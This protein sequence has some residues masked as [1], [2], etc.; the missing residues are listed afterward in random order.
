MPAVMQLGDAVTRML[1]KTASA[2]SDDDCSY[3]LQLRGGPGST[4]HKYGVDL[5]ASH[6]MMQERKSYAKGS[7]NDVRGLPPPVLKLSQTRVGRSTRAQML[8]KPRW[9]TSVLAEE[10]EKPSRRRRTVDTRNRGAGDDRDSE[11]SV[12]V[13]EDVED[14]DG[15]GRREALSVE[16]GTSVATLLV[17]RRNG[18][19][20]ID[21]MGEEDDSS[22]R[23]GNR[24][25][26]KDVFA[27]H[28]REELR[29][30]E[31][32]GVSRRGSVIAVDRTQLTQSGAAPHSWT[33]SSAGSRQT[34]PVKQLHQQG[35]AT[36]ASSSTSTEGRT[37]RPAPRPGDS[38]DTL[39][40]DKNAANDTTTAFPE[41]DFY[42][43][44]TFDLVQHCGAKGLRDR[45]QREL[46]L[47]KDMRNPVRIDLQE[48]RQLHTNVLSRKEEAVRKSYR[49]PW[50]VDKNYFE[51]KIEAIGEGRE[52]EDDER[53]SATASTDAYRYRQG[54]DYST[55]RD[56]EKKNN[57]KVGPPSRR[58]TV[59][60]HQAQ[61]NSS[62]ASSLSTSTTSGVDNVDIKSSENSGRMSV[63]EK[64]LMLNRQSEQ[65]VLVEASPENAVTLRKR[66]R[67]KMVANE[68]A[69]ESVALREMRAK[70]M[71][72]DLKLAYNPL[73]G[74]VPEK[75]DKKHADEDDA[76]DHSASPPRSQKRRAVTVSSQKMIGEPAT[77][78]AAAGGRAGDRDT[79]LLSEGRSKKVAGPSSAPGPPL[80]PLPRSIVEEEQS[81]EAEVD[82]FSIGATCSDSFV[83][84][85]TQIRG[86]NAAIVRSLQSQGLDTD[87]HPLAGLNVQGYGRRSQCS[88]D[89]EY[90][91]R[92]PD[93]GT[94]GAAGTN[95]DSPSAAS[96][97]YKFTTPNFTN[98]GKQ[99]PLG[100]PLH[101]QPPTGISFTSTTTRFPK[102]T[103]LFSRTT[104]TAGIRSEEEN[105][106][107]S[108]LR[109]QTDVLGIVIDASSNYTAPTG[110][111]V[112][113]AQTL[114]HD[115]EEDGTA[116]ASSSS[117][118]GE[119]GVEQTPSGQTQKS[120]VER[121]A[122]K[123]A[124]G[125]SSQPSGPIKEDR[126]P[127]EDAAVSDAQQSGTAAIQ[128]QEEELVFNPNYMDQFAGHR[129]S[130]PPGHLPQNQLDAVK[131]EEGHRH[132]P[133][134]P[135]KIKQQ[136][137][138]MFYTGSMDHAAAVGHDDSGKYASQEEEMELVV[139]GR[140]LDEGS[141][142]VASGWAS[143][144]RQNLLDEQQGSVDPSYE[145]SD[146]TRQR[147]LS[148]TGGVDGHLHMKNNQTSKREIPTKKKT[149]SGKK[150][151]KD[152]A[153]DDS[154]LDRLA[155]TRRQEKSSILLRNT[156][157]ERQAVLF[158][159]DQVAGAASSS[160]ASSGIDNSGGGGG[161][162]LFAMQ[163]AINYQRHLVQMR[164]QDEN[165][166]AERLLPSTSITGAALETGRSAPPGPPPSQAAL[167]TPMHRNQ[168]TNDS[169]PAQAV[170]N[171]GVPGLNS[172]RQQAPS[173]FAGSPAAT[174][175]SELI[176]VRSKNDTAAPGLHQVEHQESGSTRERFW[177]DRDR[178]AAD[179]RERNSN[180]RHQGNV[181]NKPG[182]DL[183]VEPEPERAATPPAAKRPA[184]P[185]GVGMPLASTRP[186]RSDDIG[187]SDTATNRPRGDSLS[188]L[189]HVSGD[190]IINNT[191]RSLSQNK[192]SFLPEP[193]M[194]Q[195]P[196][197]SGGESSAVTGAS[198]YSSASRRAS[199][200]ENV[201]PPGGLKSRFRHTGIDIVRGA[202]SSS[203][204]G[205]FPA[206]QNYNSTVKGKGMTTSTTSTS[207]CTNPGAN[208]PSRVNKPTATRTSSTSSSSSTTT[209][210][211][212]ST[213][214]SASGKRLSLR[215]ERHKRLDKPFFTIE[216]V[217]ITA[218]FLKTRW[219]DHLV[220]KMKS[221]L[222]QDYVRQDQKPN[223]SGG[224]SNIG[225]GG[226]GTNHDAA[227]DGTNTSGANDDKNAENNKECILCYN[228]PKDTLLA[229]CGHVCACIDCAEE[230][231]TK[232]HNCPI[233]RGYIN[234]IFRVYDS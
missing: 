199:S 222:E 8:S 4:S 178:V 121:A 232:K 139:A 216:D 204:G 195:D 122:P 84:H 35:S 61:M 156:E 150:T 205:I 55:T 213:S 34:S 210:D 77:T 189:L 75:E 105:D 202:R 161:G 135:E 113:S 229:P 42:G 140:Q 169:M 162:G 179:H 24:G 101:P 74:L 124:E 126:L 62:A 149:K 133:A 66:M 37:S 104:G 186:L 227:R 183:D 79:K 87:A 115:Q 116:T 53:D 111:Q 196:H 15:G 157:E 136:E 137:N 119:S 56:S 151:K 59:A 223:A 208:A 49:K 44:V 9:S 6:P 233:C 212:H 86:V 25:I 63:K 191:Q 47:T 219:D 131:E 43:D 182:G 98:R 141:R 73:A 83:P 148:G 112:G 46:V 153:V 194:A 2:P 118:A 50:E 76:E 134:S 93:R 203:T 20:G 41:P 197:V 214:A 193:I 7:C 173:V 97:T 70:G 176:S 144:I 172:A 54:K 5:A 30:R 32:S 60:E 170:G 36:K 224:A 91:E 71:F 39:S 225:A 166:A 90:E 96:S 10:Y 209:P 129:R 220:N 38:K 200:V 117:M 188:S 29:S 27:Q 88:S 120:S 99:A 180:R 18:R 89:D 234:D 226:R 215:Q 192:V 17:G 107:S 110:G 187:R 128:A 125:S 145:V 28:R 31:E 130:L 48:D 3:H 57:I 174:S 82:H 65:S 217:D 40:S 81:S 201:E 21:E 106:P 33:Y 16:D 206:E 163:K 51:K 138:F 108:P 167:S 11:A 198:T 230:L 175:N 221:M 22:A 64:R 68:L 143:D 127:G 100:V 164:Y 23:L 80:P 103:T 13:E 123:A 158:F 171:F 207:F 177:V 147:I 14:E 190:Q 154:F 160:S 155:E 12:E 102:K 184:P 228:A 211:L 165:A 85:P 231:L 152:N 52:V 159:A 1:A 67:E 19:S 146:P 185:S 181:I 58:P 218:K 95:S 109:L 114:A 92:D 132:A 78:G 26:S 142:I 45:F 69:G 168:G 94:G 72:S